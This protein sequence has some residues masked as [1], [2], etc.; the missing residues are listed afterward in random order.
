MLRRRLLSIVGAVG[1]AAGLL[2]SAVA[3]QADTEP[4]TMASLISTWSWSWQGAC[5]SNSGTH[6]TSGG[7]CTITQPA[8]GEDNV[9]ICVENGTTVQSC[10]ITQTQDTT[11]AEDNRAIVV[12]II[13]QGSGQQS[14][15]QTATIT[16]HNGSGR[17]DAWVLQATRQ[18]LNSGN[19][20]TQISNQFDTIDQNAVTGGQSVALGQLSSQ[21]ESSS[22]G[23]TEQQFSDQDVSDAGHHINQTSGG[24]S[25]ALVGQ[26]QLQKATGS[27]PKNQVVDP[28]CCSVQGTNMND[29]FSINQFVSQTA[30]LPTTQ[31]AHSFGI[32]Q[33]SGNCTVAQ[34]TLENNVTGSNSCSGSFCFVTTDCSSGGVEGAC[35]TPPPVTTCSDGCPSPPP[36]VC[37]P[38][39]CVPP[40]PPPIT[41][42]LLGSGGYAMA[43]VSS[44][45]ATP[46]ARSA[47]SA[48]LL[49]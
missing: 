44:T 47:P 40:P 29:R 37:P 21:T 32:C 11:S 46:V 15:S 42:R 7:T 36:P 5:Q 4:P 45:K 3:V 18:S 22:T 26:A 24:V 49:T 48:A 43:P 6:S 27:G 2:G 9:A 34:T 17:N 13:N 25:Q 23:A 14:V 41:L 39:V 38:F 19:P 12:Q 31:E 8:S 30:D 20:E 33:T 35:S 10:V 16:Q 28:R 1:L